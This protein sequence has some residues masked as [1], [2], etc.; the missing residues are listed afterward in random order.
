MNNETLTV[1]GIT[2]EVLASHT[3][4]D[5]EAR[6][7]T[8]LAQMMREQGRTREMMAKRPKGRKEFMIIEFASKWGL[9]YRVIPTSV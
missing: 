6:G 9:S 7:L 2:Y 3:V 4:A 5:I 8:N 1:D